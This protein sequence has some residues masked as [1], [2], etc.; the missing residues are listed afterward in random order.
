MVLCAVLVDATP[1]GLAE[2]AVQGPRQEAL[3]GSLLNDTALMRDMLVAGGPEGGQ[4][5]PAMDIFTAINASASRAPW[6][7]PP[8]G[9]PWDDRNQTTVLRR[10]ALGTALAHA[11][12][13][14][15][16]FGSNLTVDPLS[17]YLHYQRLSAPSSQDRHSC[18]TCSDRTPNLGCASV[19]HRDA[20]SQIN[21]LERY[22]VRPS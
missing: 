3:I 12:P 14:G 1:L 21:N 2:F 13:I 10:L 11:T 15:V 20:D 18:R 22:A 6:P 4:Y 16:A 8:Q 7:L 5:G 19:A 9:A 17:R